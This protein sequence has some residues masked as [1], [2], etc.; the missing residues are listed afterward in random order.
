LTDLKRFASIWTDGVKVGL[1]AFEKTD[2]TL[3]PVNEWQSSQQTMNF[4][5]AIILKEW[6]AAAPLER[7]IVNNLDGIEPQKHPAKRLLI[8][9]LS[10]DVVDPVL[11]FEGLASY[12]ETLGGGRLDLA[13]YPG[14]VRLTE[15]IQRLSGTTEPLLLA[16]LQGIAKEPR[17]YTHS[18]KSIHVDTP[19]RYQRIFDYMP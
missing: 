9:W 1:M 18:G 12:Q 14:G 17:F 16:F 13:G 7:A 10:T 5:F 11:P 15:R 19:S 6:H 8:A 2:K 3:K 4:D